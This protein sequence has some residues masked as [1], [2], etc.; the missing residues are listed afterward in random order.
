MKRVI[1]LVFL[2]QFL[3]VTPAHAAVL[4]DLKTTFKES[5]AQVSG[6][7]GMV[8]EDVLN[9]AS[10]IAD[11]SKNV[12][13]N[14]SR[15]SELPNLI[16]SKPTEFFIHNSNILAHETAQNI[17]SA[18][19]IFDQASNVVAHFGFGIRTFTHD[20]TLETFSTV[21]SLAKIAIN[22]P[23]HI[24]S[25]S[26][27]SVSKESFLAQVTN[28]LEPVVLSV[29]CLVVKDDIA[30]DPEAYVSRILVQTTPATET[31]VEVTVIVSTAPAN[32]ACVS[33]AVR[34]IPVLG[35][36]K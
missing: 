11:V 10:Q 24:T 4:D 33:A 22:L 32:I 18:F 7:A 34:L 27:Q 6:G 15:V 14:V 19:G 13:K 1:A 31:P 3:L 16:F 8:S 2:V 35:S 25:T 28:P 23:S 12:L 17:R 9:T 36:F 5:L 26:S 20:L 29:W 21:T 30:C